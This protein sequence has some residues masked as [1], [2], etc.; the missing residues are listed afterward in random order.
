VLISTTTIGS[1]VSS[2]VINNVFS[3]NYANYKIII[4]GGSI[5]TSN[6]VS[7]QLGPTT[8][9]AYNTGYYMNFIYNNYSSNS[10]GAAVS[11][12]TSAWTQPIYPGGNGWQAE[13]EL[14]SPQAAYRTG[15]KGTRF[16]LSGGG[17]AGPMTGFHDSTN[18]FTGFTILPQGGATLTGGIIEV[19]GYK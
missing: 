11:N 18:S 1:A 17:I 5:S 9:S 19:Y 12:N 8:V 2:I 6:P 14:L 13:F 16:D 15:L 10:V 4:N 7:V 3:S